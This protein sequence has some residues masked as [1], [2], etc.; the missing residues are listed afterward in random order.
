[1]NELAEIIHLAATK[2]SERARLRN[3][4]EMILH[5][6]S[7]EE[8][9]SPLQRAT[10][11]IAAAVNILIIQSEVLGS[12]EEGSVPLQRG[13]SRMPTARS[14]LVTEEEEPIIPAEEPSLDFIVLSNQEK[15]IRA[16][17]L[18]FFQDLINKDS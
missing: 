3:R 14:A 5:S 11:H 2:P 9:S 1:M 13:A 18:E 4:V 10:S 12:I 8:G 15:N 7:E 16:E 6:E 17:D